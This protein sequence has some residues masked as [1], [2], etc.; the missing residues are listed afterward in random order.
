MK[1]EK[2]GN[3]SKANYDEMFVNLPIHYE[4]V[5]TLTDEEKQCPACG[6]YGSPTFYQG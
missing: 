5:D 6:R 1:A 4:D 2:R 3:K